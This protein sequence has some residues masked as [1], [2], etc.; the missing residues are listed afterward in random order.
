MQRRTLALIL[1]LAMLVCLVSATGLLSVSADDTQWTG[2]AELK[3][4]PRGTELKAYMAEQGITESALNYHMN[5]LSVYTESGGTAYRVGSK[6]GSPNG[7]P[8]QLCDGDMGSY[9]DSSKRIVY[10]CSKGTKLYVTYDLQQESALTDF[11]VAGS[12]NRYDSATYLLKNVKIFVSDTAYDGKDAALLGIEVFNHTGET[13]TNVNDYNYYVHLS[14]SITGRYVTFAVGDGCQYSQL[15]L[16]ELAAY[17]T[18]LSY[19]AEGNAVRE[20]RAAQ[21][22]PTYENALKS[23]TGKL[24]DGSGITGASNLVDGVVS[25]LTTNVDFL[26]TEE[27]TTTYEKGDSQYKGGDNYLKAANGKA[28]LTVNADKSYIVQNIPLSEYSYDETDADGNKTGNTKYKRFIQANIGWNGQRIAVRTDYAHEDRNILRTA[29]KLYYDLGGVTDVEKVMVAS[30]VALYEQ[31]V[32]NAA[33][34][35]SESTLNGWNSRLENDG[36]LIV[37]N[38]KLYVADTLEELI[39]DGAFQKKALAA[40]FT[41]SISNDMDTAVELT[42]KQAR[43][44]RYI[45]FELVTDA[46]DLRLSEL[47]VKIGRKSGDCPTSTESAAAT[48]KESLLTT[49]TVRSTNLENA[50]EIAN[51]YDGD[52]KTKAQKQTTSSGTAYIPGTETDIKGVTGWAKIQ[53]ELTTEVSIDSFL[54]MGSLGDS[55]TSVNCRSR[56]I[57]YYRIYVSDSKDDL[58]TDDKR[59]VDCNNVGDNVLAAPTVNGAYDAFRNYLETPVTGR[60]IGLEATAGSY[61]LARVGEFHVYG[62]ATAD[63]TTWTD[64][65]SSDITVPANNL[66]AGVYQ[67][68]TAYEQHYLK[69]GQEGELTKWNPWGANPKFDK[70]FDGKVW[71]GSGSEDDANS[72]WIPMAYDSVKDTDAEGNAK[73]T[74]YPNYIWLDFDLGLQYNIDTFFHAAAD[75]GANTVDFFVTD[76]SVAELVA[77]K[78]EPNVYMVG[79]TSGPKG[80]ATYKRL[81]DSVQGS[82]VIVRLKGNLNVGMYQMWV[83]ELAVSGEMASPLYYKGASKRLEDNGLRFGFNVAVK[84]AA[85]ENSNPQESNDYRRNIDSATIVVNGESRPVKA[86]GA[87]VTNLKEGWESYLTDVAAAK[88]DTK[89]VQVV[90]ANN[91]YAVQTGYVTYTALVKG[92]P[93]AYKDR[94]IH[95]RPYVAYEDANGKTQYIYGEIVSSSVAAIG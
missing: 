35:I 11:V 8:R 30:G 51:L 6:V 81:Y 48:A 32:D 33:T 77:S 39:A 37:Y 63:V 26:V 38:I 94:V 10:N 69:A 25:A 17:G 70:V 67:N 5:P 66:L 14:K 16:G 86:F 55:E 3:T 28:W 29:N 91:L 45:G 27:E 40:N 76:K 23:A 60:F 9:E 87:I 56:T 65:S 47:A 12:Q 4:I 24:I 84:D 93:E 92:I 2:S 43:Q 44:G 42:L 72:K 41:Q 54:V 15:R 31:Y 85:Y 88:E 20:L 95:A 82:H 18:R 1:S 7:L 80:V 79:E 62:K 71:A 19:D 74:N 53:F 21:D 68:V 75:R 52:G 13:S 73:V 64:C 46:N 34:K 49:E 59:V 89:H 83:S 78:A 90:E 57:A 58:F 61:Y 36:K 22:L 50:S